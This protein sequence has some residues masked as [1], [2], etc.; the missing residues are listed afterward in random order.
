MKNIKLVVV[1]L[2][3]HCIPSCI[4]INVNVKLGN[5]VRFT[6]TQERLLTLLHVVSNTD[7]L[8]ITVQ[9]FVYY[10]VLLD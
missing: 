4:V 5:I 1:K 10:A 8:V 6:G 7:S 2:R 9:G 3:F